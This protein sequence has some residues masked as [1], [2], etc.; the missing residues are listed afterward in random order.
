MPL[1]L[2]GNIKISHSNPKPQR[3]TSQNKIK[4]FKL[5]TKL[6]VNLGCLY[7]IIYHKFLNTLYGTKERSKSHEEFLLANYY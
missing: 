4:A 6:L 5:F 7:E 2:R 1:R 3:T